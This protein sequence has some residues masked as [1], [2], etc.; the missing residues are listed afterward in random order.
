MISRKNLDRL[1]VTRVQAAAGVTEYRL[2]S[3]GLSILLKED[4]GAPAVNFMVLYNVGSRHEGAGYTGSA[5]FFEHLMFKG[6]RAFDPLEGNGVMEVFNRVGGELNANTSMDR[7]RYFE[8][9]PSAH[10]E[11]CVRIE[12]D[13]MRNLKN[14][15]ADRNSEMTVVRNEFERNENNPGSALYKEVVATAFKDHPYH[16]PVIGARSDVEGVPLSRMVSELYDKYYWP[17]NATVI[18]VGDF[19]SEQALGWIKKYF[20]RIS[21]SPKPI[22]QIYTVEPQQEGERR[23]ELRR[24]GP[25]PI[26]LMA[27]HTPAA[28][29][30]DIYALAAMGHILGGSS[31]PSSRLYKALFE[32]GLV[33]SVGGGVMEL[34][35]PGLFTLSASLT[36]GAKLADVE[37]LLIAELERLASEPVATEE[38]ERVKE[39]NRKGTIITMDDPMD[40]TNLLSNGVGVDTWKWSVDYDDNY[41]RVTVE[42]IQR[43]ARTY[44][45]RDNR[46]VGHFIPTPANKKPEK[47]EDSK[48]REGGNRKQK[49]VKINTTIARTNF[50]DR[51]IRHT[52]PN[53]LKVVIVQRPGTGGV[54][55]NTA[56]PAGSFQAPAG[57]ELVPSIMATLLTAGSRRFSKEQVGAAMQKM[58]T[59]LGFSAQ[60]FATK[61]GNVIA[62]TDF[63]AFVEILADTLINPTLAGDELKKRLPMFQANVANQLMDNGARANNAFSR[64]IYPEGHPYRASDLDSVP[65]DLEA[66]TAEDLQAFH[67][68]TVTPQGSVISVV[69]DIEPDAALEVI[70]A[71][72]G[73]WTGEAPKPIV[74][75]EV[76]SPLA[77]PDTPREIRIAL[78][79][80]ANVDIVIGH[81]TNLNRNAADFYAA[82]LASNALGQHTIADRLGKIVRSKHG[83]TYGINCRFGD[84]S[85]GSASFTINVSVAASNIDK[86]LKLIHEVVAEYVRDGIGTEELEDKISSACGTHVVGLRSSSAISGSLCEVEFMGWG[87][88]LL[89]DIVDGYQ[90]VTKEQVNDAIRRYFDLSQSVTVLAGTFAE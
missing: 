47:G 10:L 33:S 59:R 21:K 38:L 9:V 64:A 73:T 42:D 36:K 56:V 8:C 4:H 44:F 23:V 20:G 72:F 39:A 89:D 82:K 49:R 43:V 60:R 80:K 32:K 54:A 13:R 12:A 41:D 46:T 2:K 79:D 31:N 37:A 87:V 69:G 45:S 14:R 27:H 75:P 28:S 90:S 68:A 70:K 26:I 61:S 51:T 34:K 29:H 77:T 50:A 83:L 58:G 18:I 22:P 63:A 81:A 25:S 55:I 76:S 66:V 86:A 30:P 67:K 1:G 65:A 85:Y 19:D 17:N 16:H 57:K 88:K 5:H 48:P 24:A 52:L 74:V 15:V 6:T 71:H 78:P 53:G 7:T 3:N 11:L 84:S 40:Y 35:D 62:A